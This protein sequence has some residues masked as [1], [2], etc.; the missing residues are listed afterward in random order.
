MAFE[1]A[2]K[3]DV[4]GFS[5]G[6]SQASQGISKLAGTIQNLAIAGVAVAAIS[7]AADLVAASVRSMYSAMETGG[8]LVDLQEQTGIAIDKL[9]VMQTAFAQAGMSAED[10]QPVVNKMQ[11]AIEAAA[12]TGGTAAEVFDRLGLS[13]SK[14]SAMTADEQLRLVGNAVSGI[15]N[16]TQRA[17]TAMEIFGRAGGRALALFGAGGLDDAAKNIGNQ[18]QLMR[19][20][21]GVFDRVTDVLGTASKK[22]QG[23]FVGMASNIAPMLM[24]VVEA[25]NEIDLSGIGQQIGAV[26]AIM[27]EAFSQGKLGALVMESL[28]YAFTWSVNFLSS[29]ISAILGGAI[30]AFIEGFKILT[31]GGFWSG[32]L[33]SLVGIAQSFIQI[34]ARGIAGILD[35]WATLPGI[36]ERAAKAAAGVRQYAAEVGARGAEN[37]N[38]GA[39]AL[40]PLAIDAGKAIADAAQA[41]SAAAPQMQQSDALRTLAKGLSEDAGKRVAAARKE[42]AAKEP[43]APGGE[44]MPQTKPGGFEF[45]SSL[46]KIGGNMFGPSTGGNEAITIQRQQLEAQRAQKEKQEQTNILLKTIAGKVGSSGVVYG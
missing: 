45:V 40:K 38:A 33:T 5:T 3:M 24:S 44:L 21:A 7:K 2:L 32:M 29:A 18:A 35:Q 37:T 11:K 22:M 15:E 10:V 8:A 27:L 19:D 43:Q 34:I 17:S 31:S 12:T 30:Q 16:P 9:M 6:I 4:S 14:L 46:T 28:K 39:T 13:A 23:L 20:N 41:A 1:A 26:I 25:F 42:F 36:G